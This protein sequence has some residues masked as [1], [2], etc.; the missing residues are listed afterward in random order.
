MDVLAGLLAATTAITAKAEEERKLDEAAVGVK[1]KARRDGSFVARQLR[2][3][4]LSKTQA[5]SSPPLPK[6]A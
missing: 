1:A 2:R 6:A 5:L 4:G 3:T